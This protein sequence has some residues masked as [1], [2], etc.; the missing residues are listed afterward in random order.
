MFLN[1]GISGVFHS[2]LNLL[3]SNNLNL[4][5]II[6]GKETKPTR[7]TGKTEQHFED[8][9]QIY[10]DRALAIHQLLSRIIGKNVTDRKLHIEWTNI[11]NELYS[12]ITKRSSVD[13]ILKSM[14]KME[15]LLKIKQTFEDD[16]VMKNTDKYIQNVSSALS[17]SIRILLLHSTSIGIPKHSDN[18]E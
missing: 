7:V 6:N 1:N 2:S 4:M 14:D 13:S 15:S 16:D 17:Q 9:D 3:V 10:N 5:N 8:R 18:W 11:A 12:Y